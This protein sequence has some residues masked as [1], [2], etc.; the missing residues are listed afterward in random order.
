[1]EKGFLEKLHLQRQFELAV[2]SVLFVAGRVSQQPAVDDRSVGQKTSGG[3]QSLDSW[4][5]EVSDLGSSW[6]LILLAVGPLDPPQ[7][8]GPRLPFPVLTPTHSDGE[9]SLEGYRGTLPLYQVSKITFSVED[10]GGS[11]RKAIGLWKCRWP[12]LL[13]VTCPCTIRAI[14]PQ[15]WAKFQSELSPAYVS[16]RSSGSWQWL[17]RAPVS[18][19]CGREAHCLLDGAWQPLHGTR[20]CGF[21]QWRDLLKPGGR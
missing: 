12:P 11:A 5:P 10:L 13:D 18:R 21:W 8:L 16:P 1:M 6:F 19:D 15:T 17:F 2:P 7:F 9:R 3:V 4:Y 14:R 20:P